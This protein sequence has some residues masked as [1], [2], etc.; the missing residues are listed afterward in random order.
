MASLVGNH[1]TW[2]WAWQT[3]AV[4]CWLILSLALD[5][6]LSIYKDTREIVQSY[7]P[8]SHNKDEVGE[9][10]WFLNTLWVAK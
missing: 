8:Y 6:G 3:W 10:I 5:L 4:L 7:I 2:H 1:W 9:I